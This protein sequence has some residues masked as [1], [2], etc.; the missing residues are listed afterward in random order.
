MHAIGSFR[1]HISAKQI[2]GLSEIDEVSVNR[3]ARRRGFAD[4]RKAVRFAEAERDA[5]KSLALL[6]SGNPKAL[7]RRGVARKGLGRLDD[8]KQGRSITLFNVRVI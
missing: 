1:V 8:A 5:S 4:V 7:F 6:P 3:H 2:H